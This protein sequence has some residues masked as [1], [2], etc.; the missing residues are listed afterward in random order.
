MARLNHCEFIGN[1]GKDPV[2]KEFPGGSKIATLNLAIT[3]KWKDRSGQPQEHTEWV[4]LVFNEGLAKTVELYV[5]KGDALYVCGRMR[6][7]SYTDAQGVQKY[8]TEIVVLDMQMLTRRDGAGAQ[9]PAAASPAA[10]AGP[11]D[12]PG[13]DLPF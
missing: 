2:V 9:A 6:T 12:N 3:E 13:D 11:E 7:R 4:P 10:P 5:H 8:T 1:V